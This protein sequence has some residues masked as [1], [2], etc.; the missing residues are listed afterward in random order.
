T[1][2]RIPLLWRRALTA[3]P[4]LVVLALPVSPGRALLYSQ[5]LLSFGIP[6]VLFPLLVLARDNRVMGERR[7]GTAAS[8]LLL[9]ASV[10][11]T[12]LNAYLTGQLIASSVQS[13][14]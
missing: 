11:I 13:R 3:M 1:G 14:A 10:A 8:L 5:V 7:S 6:F 2:R 4:S 9:A 12:A